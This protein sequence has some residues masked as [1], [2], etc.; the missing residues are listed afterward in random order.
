[1]KTK[2]INL[3]LIAVINVFSFQLFAQ[4]AKDKTIKAP[5][6]SSSTSYEKYIDDNYDVHLKEFMELIAIPSISSIPA[7]KPDVERAAAWV[8]NK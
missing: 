6:K 2:K 1:M 3:V 4:K 8:V 7:N 5:Q